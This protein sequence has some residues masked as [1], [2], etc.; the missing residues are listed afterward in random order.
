LKAEKL[1][2][3]EKFF[4][5]SRLNP[6]SFHQHSSALDEKVKTVA[7]GERESQKKGQTANKKTTKASSSKKQFAFLRFLL[8]KAFFGSSESDEKTELLGNINENKDKQRNRG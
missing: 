3:N 7:D 6:F 8:G 2:K 1:K 5:F 4:H